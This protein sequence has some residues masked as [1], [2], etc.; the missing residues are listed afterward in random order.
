LLDTLRFEFCSASGNGFPTHSGLKM[1]NSWWTGEAAQSTP[2]ALKLAQS[3]FVVSEA[4][5]SRFTSR[6]KQA[7]LL[8]AKASGQL[9]SFNASK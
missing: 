8:L 9:A 4:L 2:R 3:R 5:T 6:L 1:T 7:F